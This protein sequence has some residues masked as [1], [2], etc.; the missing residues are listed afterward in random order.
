MNCRMVLSCRSAFFQS[1][2]DCSIHAKERSTI[3]RLGRTAKVCT[4]SVWPP[5][6]LR[7]AFLVRQALDLGH[8]LA[9]VV[10]FMP[11]TSCVFY[12]LRIKDQEARLYVAPLF[13]TGLANLIFLKPAPG[14]LRHPGRAHSTWQS[15]NAPSAISE[16]HWAAFATG[17]RS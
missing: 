2:Q 7:R 1:L 13:G 6:P 16:T 5:E 14:H 17:S 15:T 11:G 4:H 3:H 10:A 8:F 9:C 12:A